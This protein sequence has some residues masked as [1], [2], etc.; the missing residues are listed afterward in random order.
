MKIAI[1]GGDSKHLE[2][3]D[4]ELEQLIEESGNYLFTVIG[5]YIEEHAGASL[6]QLY[7]ELRGAPYVTTKYKDLDSLMHKTAA[8]AD[9]IIFMNDGSQ[10]IKRFIMVYHQTGKHGSVINI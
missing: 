8:A 10:L 4:N 5:G 7:A 6:G 1:I 9:Y 3:V 2:M